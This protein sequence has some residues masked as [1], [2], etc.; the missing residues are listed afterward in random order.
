MYRSKSKM[1]RE[2][3]EATSPESG[4]VR[5]KCKFTEIS[6]GAVRCDSR[7]H[8]ESPVAASPHQPE[9]GVIPEKL[10]R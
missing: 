3:N 5:Q 8:D 1:G 6:G 7:C 4:Q 9:A 10:V 2:A